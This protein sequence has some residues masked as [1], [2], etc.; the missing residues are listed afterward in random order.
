MLE[1]DKSAEQQLKQ[2]EIIETTG[3]KMKKTTKERNL[4]DSKGE[5]MKKVEGE[6]GKKEGI[7]KKERKVE[8]WKRIYDGSAKRLGK[9]KT[10]MAKIAGRSPPKSPNKQNKVDGKKDANSGDGMV[11]KIEEEKK[12]VLGMIKRIRHCLPGNLNC[13]KQE[14]IA[15]DALDPS[16]ETQEGDKKVN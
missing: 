8:K 14:V 16:N 2:I 5:K 7:E 3:E 11:P 6:K 4:K 15:I 9:I 10:M 1:E 13:F 12:V